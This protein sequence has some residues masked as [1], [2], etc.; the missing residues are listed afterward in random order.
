MHSK[1][2][3]ALHSKKSWNISAKDYYRIHKR[4]R[5]PIIRERDR[6]KGSNKKLIVT[7]GNEKYYIRHGIKAIRELSTNI[8]DMPLNQIE[9]FEKDYLKVKAIRQKAIDRQIKS[10]FFKKLQLLE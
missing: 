7:I 5:N 1:K 2:L 4:I 10:K 9:T 3:K 8:K 6:S